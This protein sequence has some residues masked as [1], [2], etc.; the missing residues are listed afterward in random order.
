MLVKI[1]LDD[2]NQLIQTTKGNLV[3]S[4]DNMQLVPSLMINL[5][6]DDK[7]QLSQIIKVT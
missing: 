4:L 2:G 7:N 6:L 3:K 5:S 1:R